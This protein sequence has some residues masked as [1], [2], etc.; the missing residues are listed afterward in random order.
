MEEFSAAQPPEMKRVPFLH[1]CLSTR[2]AESLHDEIGDEKD[3]KNDDKYETDDKNCENDEN[4]GLPK[5]VT[6]LG[7]MFGKVLLPSKDNASRAVMMIT[8]IVTLTTVVTILIVIATTMAGNALIIRMLS[9]GSN[10][11]TI[12]FWRC[13]S[14]RLQMYP[15]SS[16]HQKHNDLTILAE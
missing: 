5:R 7:T 11:A 4:G 3:N 2:S 16:E 1:R 12:A 15:F 14:L 9:M 13:L 8:M 6:V 10:I